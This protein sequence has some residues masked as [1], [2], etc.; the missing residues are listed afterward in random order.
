MY[1][2]IGASAGSLSESQAGMNGPATIAVIGKDSS[3]NHRILLPFPNF[4][5]S[6]L[7]RY[8]LLP[9]LVLIVVGIVLGLLAVYVMSSH[10]KK[11][12]DK[13]VGLQERQVRDH[14]GFARDSTHRNDP[15]I[16]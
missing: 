8:F 13:I 11:E 14:N 9:F 4:L 6:R 3:S 16:T 1:C 7:A 5:P 15:E 12:F 10:A 2:F